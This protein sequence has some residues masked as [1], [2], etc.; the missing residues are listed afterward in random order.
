MG[1]HSAV[2]TQKNRHTERHIKKENMAARILLACLMVGLAMANGKTLHEML[3]RDANPC[4]AP[5][6]ASCAPA[7]APVCCA[8]A[9]PP[10]P[11]PPVC[12]TTCVPTCPQYCC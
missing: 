4:G 5:C 11:C 3:K 12:V 9:P 7:C 8:P 6:P 10:P 1:C 2:R